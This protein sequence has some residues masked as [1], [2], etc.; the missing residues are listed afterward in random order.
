M[1]GILILGDQQVI[2]REFA[3]PEPGPGQVVVRVRAAAICG[4][5]LHNWYWRSRE[6]LARDGRESVIPGHE[7]SGV[8]E[9]VGPG[10]RGVAVGDRVVVWCHCD[11]VCGRCTHCLS[12]E[13][14][15]CRDV[16]AEPRRRPGHGADAELLLA[17]DWQCMTL[18]DALG[19]EAGAVAAC[20]LGTAYQAL[21]RLD[22]TV[23][24]TVAIVG[25]GP[26]GLATLLV[27]RSLGARTIVTEPV[28]ERL[29]LARALGADAV[30]DP[31]K[32]IAPGVVR[33]LT[34]GA[35]ANAV[36]ETSGSPSGQREA[37]EI[38]RPGGRIG[39]VGFG[40]QG[41]RREYTISPDRFIWKQLTLVGSFVYPPSLF[42]EIVD[43]VVR[44]RL[45]LEDLVTHRLPL[46]EAE[47][48]F[49]LFD[50]RRTGKV[51]LL[52]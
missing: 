30:V 5:D 35:G 46:T 14:W 39:F 6:E 31:A 43:Y 18:P 22:A 42:P 44:Q 24:Q 26:T 3:D 1:R 51:V 19:F 13:E 23:G 38:A 52:P 33:E 49:R 11:G 10:A 34:G 41:R 4:S 17:Q 2:V 12:G 45:A 40:S 28:P 32:E 25:A 36:V 29:D 15:F 50:T 8:V 20:S 21:R 9:A 37:I 27:A 16:H 48:A 47:Q 7:P